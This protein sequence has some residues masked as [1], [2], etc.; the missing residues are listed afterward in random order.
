MVREGGSESISLGPI[1]KLDRDMVSILANAR[2]HAGYD[3][4]KDPDYEQAKR[5]L[6]YPF[7]FV[8]EK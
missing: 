5:K 3:S 1:F 6:P 8:P 2:L 7:P 4:I